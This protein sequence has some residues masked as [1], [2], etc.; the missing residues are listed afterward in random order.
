MH[1]A[2][3][4][5]DLFSGSQRSQHEAAVWEMYSHTYAKIGLHVARGVMLSKYPVWLICTNQE[6][7]AVFFTVFKKTRFGLKGALSGHNGSPEGKAEAKYRLRHMYKT[8]GYYAELSGV[9]AKIALGARTPVICNAWADDIIDREVEPVGDSAVWY[10]RQLGDL[11]NFKK[12]LT[13]RPRGVQTTNLQ[14]PTCPIFDPDLDVNEWEPDK[15]YDTFSRLA[16]DDDDGVDSHMS[17]L[18][19]ADLD[20]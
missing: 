13:G 10:T 11:G 1:L 12:V 9:P 4:Q 15:D 16:D 3:L 17:C 2:G 14:N 18:A 7:V 6:G 8:P 19:L 20:D 5:C